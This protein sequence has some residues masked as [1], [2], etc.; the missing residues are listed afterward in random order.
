MSAASALVAGA[1]Y[2]TMGF[3]ETMYYIAAL[4]GLAAVVFAML[5]LSQRTGG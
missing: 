2:E 3:T 5:P 4:F 1:I